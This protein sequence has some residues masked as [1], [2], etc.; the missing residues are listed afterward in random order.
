MPADMDSARLSVLRE[1]MARARF[2]V[3]TRRRE[4]GAYVSRAYSLDRPSRDGEATGES[5]L[6]SI[7]AL[8]A[9]CGVACGPGGDAPPPRD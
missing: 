4:D 1:A 8:A 6:A 9:L 3:S 2:A 7:E 5:E